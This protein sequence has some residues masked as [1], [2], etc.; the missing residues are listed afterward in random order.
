MS[1]DNLYKKREKI[2]DQIFNERL[3]LNKVVE[4]IPWGAGMRRV[5]VNPSC[6]KLDRLREKLNIVNEQINK[7]SKGC[8]IDNG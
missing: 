8:V 5:K 2:E 1:I 6:S 4:N 3:R 7:I